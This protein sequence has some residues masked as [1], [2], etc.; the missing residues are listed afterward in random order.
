M[1]SKI[2]EL[3]NDEKSVYCFDIDGVLVPMEFGEYN[4]FGLDDDVWFKELYKRDL[5]E[6]MRVN[7]TIQEF[8][9]NKDMSRVYIVTKVANEEEKNQKVRFVSKH[10][11]IF[12]DNVYMVSNEKDKLDKMN[13][14]KNIYPG[15]EDKYM[16]MID[17]SV[18]VLNNIKENSNYSTVHISSFF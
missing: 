10:Y 5:Y 6:S 4:H 11:G 7:K 8:L 9:K 18:S 15:L 3:F 17:D 2:N 16:I 1:I 12:S 13:I 14:I